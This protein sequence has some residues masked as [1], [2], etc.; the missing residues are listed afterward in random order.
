[1][2]QQHDGGIDVIEYHNIRILIIK[3]QAEKVGCK[4]FFLPMPQC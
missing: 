1:M 2:I 3:I 4:V